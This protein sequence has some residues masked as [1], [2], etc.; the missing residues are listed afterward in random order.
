MVAY[1]RILSKPEF[2]SRSEA[3]RF[4]SVL[5]LAIVVSSV[6]QSMTEANINE[7]SIFRFNISSQLVGK[8]KSISLQGGSWRAQFLGRRRFFPHQHRLGQDA[9]W[10]FSL[11]WN[12]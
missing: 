9:L 4:Q 7:L 2:D 5:R 12:T 11:V 1:V 10:G 8:D 3:H 6:G